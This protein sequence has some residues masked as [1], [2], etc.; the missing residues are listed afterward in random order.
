VTRT[1]PAVAVAALATVAGCGGSP[2]AP[3]PPAQLSIQ[4]PASFQIR[5]PDGMG[6]D[7][8]YTPQM[9]GGLEPSVVCAPPSGTTLPLGEWN[10]TCTASDSAG[11]SATCSFAVRVVEPRRLQYTRFLAFGDSI[12]QGV[13]SP[14]P[15]ILRRLDGPHTYP[16]LL[17]GLLAARYTA[18]SV[19]VLNRGIA[20]ERLARGRDRLPG[21]LDD[22]QP[23][24]LLLLEGINNLRNVDTAV[25]TADMRSMIRTAQR[26]GAVVLVAQLLPISDARE[27]TR[28]GQG[29][30]AGIRAFNEQI[31]RLSNELGLGEA[32][33]LYT[34][35]VE[36]P[37]LLGMDGLHPTEAGYVRIA[38]I[39]FAAIAERWEIAPAPLSAAPASTLPG[40]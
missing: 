18:Q 23:E 16:S 1:L 20:G 33:D 7:I 15:A 25:L 40:R 22:D 5:S 34:P 26:R 11:Q 9:S 39:F 17:Q 35:F 6:A 37:S 2:T 38:E 32:V 3:A 8:T 27:A 12:T 13:V 36:N 29:T 28:S 30:Q 14:A 21:V 4:C 31:R 19:E 24:V 10:I